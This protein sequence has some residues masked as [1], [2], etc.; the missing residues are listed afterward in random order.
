MVM[1]RWSFCQI[2]AMSCHNNVSHVTLMMS[3]IMS[4]SL[5]MSYFSSPVSRIW[6]QSITSVSSSQIVVL[7]LLWHLSLSQTASMLYIYSSN[8]IW[9]N[10]VTIQKK[11]WSNNLNA[12]HNLEMTREI[13][14]DNWWFS[15]IFDRDYKVYWRLE[16]SLWTKHERHGEGGLWMSQLFHGTDS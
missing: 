14:S 13:N 8:I 10:K 5:M 1:E 15:H 9:N 4:Y 2:L 11:I 12:R 6:W 16:E 3:W 7:S